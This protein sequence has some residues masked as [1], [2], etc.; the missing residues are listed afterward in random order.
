MGA[1]KNEI[2]LLLTGTIERNSSDVLAVKDPEIRK[3]QYLE[4]ISFYLANTPYKIVFSENSG[5]SLAEYFPGSERLEFITFQ[6]PITSP[7]RGK[8]WKELE[9][10]DYTLKKS[11]FIKETSI[12]VKIT[13]RLKV[14]NINKLANPAQKLMSSNDKL[15]MSNIYKRLKMDS[16]CFL[17]TKEFWPYLKE[18][19]DSINLGFSFEKALWQAIMDFKIKEKGSYRQFSQPLRI[20]GISGGFGTPYKHGSLIIFA[21]QLKHFLNPIAYREILK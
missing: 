4:A 21:K 19:G 3:Q 10:I 7:D 1:D 8:G 17:F 9:I 15:V 12:V 16:R 5:Y 18:N 13:G 14:L 6:S 20:K 2:V 11:G